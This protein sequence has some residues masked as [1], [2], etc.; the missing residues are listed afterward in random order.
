MG[1][2]AS[3][4]TE[5]TSVTLVTAVSARLVRF[6]VCRESCTLPLQ[7]V[8]RGSAVAAF[9][10]FSLL[11]GLASY[12][13]YAHEVV[14]SLWT[15]EPALT[16]AIALAFVWVLLDA[17]LLV[18]GDGLLVQLLK[19]LNEEA[20]SKP[21]VP[22]NLS[23]ISRCTARFDRLGV[24]ATP[25]VGALVAWVAFTYSLGPLSDVLPASGPLYVVVAYV[26][27]G[28]VGAVS[29]YGI[30]GLAKGIVVVIEASK[31]LNIPWDPISPKQ[32]AGVEELG[33]FS[34]GIAWRFSVG[35]VFAPA[36][37]LAL[38]NHLVAAPAVPLVAAFVALLM[39]GGLAAFLVPRHFLGAL[40]RR[41]ERTY[42]DGVR[43]RIEP[44]V[45]S[46]VAGE[47]LSLRSYMQIHVALYQWQ[48]ARQESAY[49][50]VLT[51]V[52]AS[53]RTLVF[54]LSGFIIASALQIL[55]R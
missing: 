22:W 16:L 36:I 35:S 49:A 7:E 14:P 12:L 55:T 38:F 28:Q 40:A 15:S 30:W 39:F 47:Q 41:Q 11:P 18:R 25:V 33:D 48:L 3:L 46:D 4:G 34:L 42:L 8:P 23:N 17:P 31:S 24:W 32:I 1:E 52:G 53:L 2:N 54:P 44:L 20:N 6:V 29:A 21:P 51:A 43:E 27:I 19:T 45:R 50:S 13:W 26:V 10:V 5:K 9:L 37:L